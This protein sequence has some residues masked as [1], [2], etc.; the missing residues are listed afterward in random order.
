M[1]NLGLL[2][3]FLLFFVLQLLFIPLLEIKG[4][5][6]DLLLVFVIL[7]GLQRERFWGTLVGFFVGLLQDLF[8]TGF[9]GVFT[10][11][12]TIS[13]FLVRAF[14][15]KSVNNGVLNF[16]G[17]VFAIGIIHNF[18]V[19]WI[20]AWGTHV[21]I[22]IMIFR[23]VIPEAFYTAVLAMIVYELLPKSAFRQYEYESR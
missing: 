23:F 3:L 10:I 20:S 12:K 1:T 8:C 11:A 18:L 19:D 15:E 4:I 5:K 13:G 14:S 7:V 22:L 9:L 6:P 17:I 21:S 16:G 2:I